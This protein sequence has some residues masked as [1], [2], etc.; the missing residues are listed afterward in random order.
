MIFD[1]S[2]EQIEDLLSLYTVMKEERYS[3]STFYNDREYSFDELQ[4][5]ELDQIHNIT[6]K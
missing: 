1:K 2:Y 4:N 5:L 3:L 6:D